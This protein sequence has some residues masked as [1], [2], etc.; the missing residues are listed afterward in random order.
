MS[1]SYLATSLCQHSSHPCSARKQSKMMAA[2]YHLHCIPHCPDDD[3]SGPNTSV[4]KHASKHNWNVCNPQEL[5]NSDDLTTNQCGSK[6][7][8]APIVKRSKQSAHF[9]QWYTP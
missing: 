5:S 4:L 9:Q 2:T 3:D 7:N 6:I 8:K 1:P